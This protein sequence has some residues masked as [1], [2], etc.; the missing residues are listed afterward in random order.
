MFCLVDTCHSGT[1]LDFE[2]PVTPRARAF[3]VSACSDQETA[4]E[5]ISD[6]GGWGGKLCAQF[7]DYLGAEPEH[8]FDMLKFHAKAAAVF[9]RQPMQRSTAVLSAS[10]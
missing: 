10:K 3:A 6:F 1:M 4:G 2:C 9:A 8:Q 7:F 5:D